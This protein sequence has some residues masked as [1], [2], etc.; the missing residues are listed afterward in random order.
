M[1]SALA[2]QLPSYENIFHRLRTL[3]RRGGQRDFYWVVQGSLVGVGSQS[4]RTMDA[5]KVKYFK[6]TGVR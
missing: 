1:H 4:R 3:E 6:K 2:I 5:M